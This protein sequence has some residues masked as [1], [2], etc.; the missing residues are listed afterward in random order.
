MKERKCLYCTNRLMVSSNPYFDD[1]IIVCIDC[2]KQR[3]E[4]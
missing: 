3:E 4:E 1:W 2:V